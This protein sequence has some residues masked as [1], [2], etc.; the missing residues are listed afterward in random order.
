MDRH[1][2]L[3]WTTSTQWT[4]F[5][6]MVMII[7]SWVDRKKKV[8]QAGQ[9]LFFLL[10][11]F[12]LWILLSKQ[13]VVPEVQSGLP[14]PEAKA[15]TYFRGLV[16]TGVTGLG[17]FLLGLTKPRWEKF[18]DIVLIVAAL[19]LFFMVYNLQQLPQ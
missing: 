10:G 4:L 19:M 18:A 1:L 17:G 9:I 12:S 3:A 11:I 13:I 16:I 15:L 6:A 7:I 14:L 5:F 2:F 8:R